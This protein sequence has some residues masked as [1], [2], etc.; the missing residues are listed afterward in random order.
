MTSKQCPKC[1]SRNFQIYDEW[2]QGLLYEVTDGFVEANGAGDGGEHI[3]TSCTC[4]ECGY[5]WH[6]RKLEYTIDK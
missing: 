1:R 3:R 5:H 4:R 2:V 6:P